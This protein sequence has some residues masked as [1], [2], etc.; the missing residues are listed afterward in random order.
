MKINKVF[1]LTIIDSFQIIRF[2]IIFVF[3]KC[4]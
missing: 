2:L 1:R 3:V 4:M